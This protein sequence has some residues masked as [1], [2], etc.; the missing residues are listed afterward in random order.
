[1]VLKPEALKV[2]P[3]ILTAYLKF[4]EPFGIPITIEATLDG[5]PFDKWT[6]S[7]EAMPEEGLEA[8]IVI[9]RFR[10]AD[11]EEALLDTE[12]V[13]KGK[14]DDGTAPLGQPYDFEGHDSISKIIVGTAPPEKS[15]GKK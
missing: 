10:R 11:I 3:G 15:K 1:M 8:P 2:N 13:L 12:F 7:Y 5:A 9:M 14:F 4:P 6:I